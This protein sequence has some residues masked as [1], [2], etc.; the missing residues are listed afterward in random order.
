MS[1]LE[2]KII[3]LLSKSKPLTLAEIAERLNKKPNVVFKA[4]RKLFE[5]GIIGCDIKTRKYYLEEDYE[6]L[7]EDIENTET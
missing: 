3:E 2:E 7:E 5:K 6:E 4:L 1:K